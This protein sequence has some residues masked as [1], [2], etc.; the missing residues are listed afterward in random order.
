MARIML[1]KLREFAKT[2]WPRVKSLW[3]SVVLPWLKE[4]TVKKVVYILFV[5]G[6]TGILFV[7]FLFVIFSFGL[8]PVETLKDYQPLPGTVI[9][10]DDGKVLGRIKIEK[11][12]HVPL[13]RIP[14]FLKNAV[15]ATEDPRFYEHKG[16]DYRGILRAAL[17]DIIAVRLKQG[18]ST[19]TQQL[20]KV[21]FLTPR[22]SVQRKI[23]EVI[24]ARRLE[25]EISKDEILEHYLN[26]IYF[27][28]GA[29][30]VQMAARTYFGKNIW[31]INEAEAALLAGLPKAPVVYSPYNDVDLTSCASG[32]CWGGWLTKN[33]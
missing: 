12:I 31:Q 14:K 27:G 29:Y 10:G 11:G 28:Q 32:T 20:T 6:L 9:Y 3:T 13:D 19:I 5:T 30:G 24:L 7:V 8:P 1:H 23:K 16:L 26:R 21:V 17:K 25:K 15:L 18:G 4:L 2:L 22:R 33:S